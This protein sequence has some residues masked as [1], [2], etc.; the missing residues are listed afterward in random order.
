MQS[1][2]CIYVGSYHS[3]QTSCCGWSHGST[4]MPQVIVQQGFQTAHRI[5]FTDAH[6]LHGRSRAT[7]MARVSAVEGCLDV[8]SSTRITTAK[9]IS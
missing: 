8:N 6:G 5:W 2:S 9:A 1:T 4:A 3:A 7:C